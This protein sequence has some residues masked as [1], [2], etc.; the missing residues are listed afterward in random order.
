MAELSRSLFLSHSFSAVGQIMECARRSH[1]SANA[2]ARAEGYGI[3][4]IPQQIRP[5]KPATHALTFCTHA[6]SSFH[7]WT[8]SLP[9]ILPLAVCCAERKIWGRGGGGAGGEDARGNAEAQIKP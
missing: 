3:R 9:L 1:F 6:P 5:K 8:V 4:Q 7:Y 2:S